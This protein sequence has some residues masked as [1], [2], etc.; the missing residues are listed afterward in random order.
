[1]LSYEASGVARAAPKDVWAAW[2]DVASWSESEHIES[3]RLDG[4]FR[5]GGVIASKAKGLP[6][7]TL[8]ITRVEPPRLWVDESRFPGVK[9]TFEHVIEPGEAGTELTERVLISGPL[10]RLVG[11]LLRRKLEAL[12][13]A[14]VARVARRAEEAGQPHGAGPDEHQASS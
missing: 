6:R 2:V 4:E 5:P 8:T 9:M 10:G 1:V 13:A 7:S 12:F 11:V 3:A 14:S